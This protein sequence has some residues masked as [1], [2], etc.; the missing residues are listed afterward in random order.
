MKRDSLLVWKAAVTLKEKKI[1][2]YNPLNPQTAE[3]KAHRH[4]IDKPNTNACLKSL[5]N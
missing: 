2:Q 5:S 4:F 3:T 1:N